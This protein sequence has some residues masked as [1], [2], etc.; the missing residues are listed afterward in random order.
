MLTASSPKAPAKKSE[1]KKT[2]AKKRLLIVD[3]N[4]FFYRAYYA[5]RSLSNSRGEPTN[6]IY[7]FVTMMQKLIEEFEPSHFA[8]CFDS[9]DWQTSPNPINLSVFVCNVIKN[10]FHILGNENSRS[11]IC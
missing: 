2:S 5:I 8:I 1:K 7:G 10:F 3:G 9:K 4:A 6:A 11:I